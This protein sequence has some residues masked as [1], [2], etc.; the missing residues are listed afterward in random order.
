MTT[1]LNG[2]HAAIVYTEHDCLPSDIGVYYC[3]VLYCTVLY[4]TVLYCTVLYCTV[5]YCIVLYCTAYV[6]Y[7]TV[8]YC[9]VLYFT[10]LHCT[11]LYFTVLHCTSLYCLCLYTKF[12]LFCGRAVYPHPP[13]DRTA[14][15]ATIVY[16]NNGL[17]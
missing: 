16:S 14:A 7:C 3:T 4:C 11:V 1:E 15:A 9:T 17:F 12:L 13:A 10:V 6:L 2:R 5:L 8:L